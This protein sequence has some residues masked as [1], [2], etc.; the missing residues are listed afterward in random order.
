MVTGQIRGE[1][2]V[3]AVDRANAVDDFRQRRQDVRMR[4]VLRRQLIGQG[5][6]RLDVASHP[7]GEDLQGGEDVPQPAVEYRRRRVRSGECGT[8]FDMPV[9]HGRCL[10]G[11]QSEHVQSELQRRFFVLRTNDDV[12]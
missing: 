12:H 2:D 3:R 1:L 10:L 5:H 4:T 8:C 6:E 9:E 11:E 7:V